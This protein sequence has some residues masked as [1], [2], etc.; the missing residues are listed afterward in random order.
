VEEDVK[1]T[2]FNTPDGLMESLVL[3]QGDIS[4]S[5]CLILELERCF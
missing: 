3:Q 1:K 4:K 5:I 2:L